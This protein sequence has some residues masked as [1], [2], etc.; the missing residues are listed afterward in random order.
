VCI[1]TAS[2]LFLFLFTSLLL[3]VQ[4]VA[5]L[6]LILAALAGILA[7]DF[8]SGFVHWGADT[9]GTVDTFIGRVGRGRRNS[10]LI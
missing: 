8:I 10:R 7:A 3:H 2:A 6:N 9:W 4:Q 5:L 1:Y